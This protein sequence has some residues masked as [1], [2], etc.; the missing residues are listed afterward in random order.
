MTKTAYVVASWGG[1]RRKPQHPRLHADGGLYVRENVIRAL[2]LGRG[3][4][5]IVIAAPEGHGFYRGYEESLTQL[6]EIGA[7][8]GKSVEVLRRPNIGLSYGSLNDVYGK[9]MTSFDYYIFTEDD[10][11]P[12]TF[13]FDEI[14]VRMIEERPKCGFLCGLLWEVKDYAQGCAAIFVG[15]FRSKALE[16]VWNSRGCL[17][18]FQGNDYGE[19]EHAGQI[20]ISTSLVQAGYAIEDWTKH[21]SSPFH[22]ETGVVVYGDPKAPALFIPAQTAC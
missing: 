20:G 9:Y 4:D 6:P 17:A 22:K 10:Y 13:D 19:A 14:L 15:I 18:R 21:Y 1:A 5:R 7:H 11:W 2:S 12:A 3:L 8:M 16:A